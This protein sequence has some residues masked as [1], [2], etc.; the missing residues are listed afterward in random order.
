MDS[1][2]RWP[3]WKVTIVA[4]I[5]VLILAMIVTLIVYAAMSGNGFTA[6]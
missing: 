1:T 2:P 4:A 6:D 3:V 5:G